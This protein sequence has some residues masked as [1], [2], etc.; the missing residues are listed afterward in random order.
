[1][2]EAIL[3]WVGIIVMGLVLAWIY[4]NGLATDD[5]PWIAIGTM[6]LFGY[7]FTQCF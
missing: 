5:S 3:P 7:I 4:D 2:G 1:M 6:L